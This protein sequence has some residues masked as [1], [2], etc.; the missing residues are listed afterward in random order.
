[1]FELRLL[2]SFFRSG[3]ACE[4]DWIPHSSGRW[5]DVHTSESS[6][7]SRPLLEHYLAAMSTACGHQN[8]S[9]QHFHGYSFSFDKSFVDAEC[10][11]LA[12]FLTLIL[13]CL[14]LW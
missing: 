11:L 10:P 13:V 8:Q 2:C 14:D 6:V 5:E 3:A 4:L 1:M 9:C 7:V 12:C